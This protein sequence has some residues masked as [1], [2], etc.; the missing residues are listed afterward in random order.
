MSKIVQIANH[1]TRYFTKY[2]DFEQFHAV[3][4]TDY[5]CCPILQIYTEVPKL[6]W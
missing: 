4:D 5:D 3:L 1:K 2:V 6:Y